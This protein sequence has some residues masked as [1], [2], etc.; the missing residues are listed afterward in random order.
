MHDRQPASSPTVRDPGAQPWPGFALAADAAVRQLAEQLPM[1]LWLVT[2]LDR[3]HQQIVASYGDWDA[4]A[5]PGSVL[6]WADSFCVRMINGAPGLATDVRAVPD[7]AGVAVGPYAIVR[8]YLG[9]PLLT[10]DGGLFGSLCGFAGTP[11]P[12]SADS[13]PLVRFVGRM[14]STVLT[15]ES[16]A[17]ERSE[18][19]AEAYALVDRD[20]ATGLGNARGWQ[21]ALGTENERCRRFG[22]PASVIVLDLSELGRARDPDTED[23]EDDEDQPD[24]RVTGLAAAAG[25]A[26]LGVSPDRRRR[27]PRA[28]AALHDR[29]RVRS[30]LGPR[31]GHPHPPRAAVG[32]ARRRDRGVRDAARRR[33]PAVGLAARP[34]G[35]Q[36][37]PAAPGAAPPDSGPAGVG[38]PQPATVSP[39]AGRRPGQPP[40]PRQPQRS[41]SI[42]R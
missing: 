38:Q 2:H 8:C 23:D 27:A 3:E 14:L 13:Y 40:S 10:A 12:D 37:R 11:R 30:R 42:A 31:A 9:T 19:A 25:G 18:A 26:G 29:R 33:G 1:D 7:Y 5:P 21:R 4:I 41:A 24:G 34:T 32:G 28:C 35:E 22:S 36:P 17:A 16:L 15:R 6:P 20:M 39:R